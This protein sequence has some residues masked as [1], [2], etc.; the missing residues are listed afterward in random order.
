MVQDIGTYLV[1]S[2]AHVLDLSRLT[3]TLDPKASEVRDVG[4]FFDFGSQASIQTRQI[5]D[6]GSLISSLGPLIRTFVSC[7]HTRFDTI[8]FFVPWNR[9]LFAATA[10]I[11]CN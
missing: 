6:H 7:W 9:P 8:F 3:L 4:E 5:N 1:V 11:Y 2:V 10:C